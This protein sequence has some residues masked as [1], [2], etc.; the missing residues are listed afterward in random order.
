MVLSLELFA[1][2]GEAPAGHEEQA[3]D[4]DVEDIEH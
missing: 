2:L 3:A 1:R 4:A